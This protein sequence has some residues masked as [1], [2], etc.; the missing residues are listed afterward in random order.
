MVEFNWPDVGC[1]FADGGRGHY[2]AFG[3]VTLRILL[4]FCHSHAFSKLSV[5]IVTL[6]VL[7]YVFTADGVYSL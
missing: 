2:A 1:V 5:V 6:C 4:P 7:Y 3:Y